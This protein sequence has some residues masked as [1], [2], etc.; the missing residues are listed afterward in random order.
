MLESVSGI[1]IPPAGR[2]TR[3]VVV[4]NGRPDMLE[5]LESVLDAGPYDVVFVT[6]TG[7][8]YSQ[9]RQNRPDLVI[10]CVGVDDPV[11]VQVLSMLKLD[12][13]TSAIPVLTYT[14]ELDA[15]RTDDEPDGEQ[16]EDDLA[17]IRPELPMN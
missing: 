7:H 3:K 11:S 8:A 14:N 10:L 12:A 16:P 2:A 9:I 13:D 17:M 4:V 1:P 15:D 6:E 5:L